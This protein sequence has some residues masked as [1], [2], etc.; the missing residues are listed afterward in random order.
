MHGRENN[1]IRVTLMPEYVAPKKNDS[2]REV[3]KKKKELENAKKP[4]RKGLCRE[5]KKEEKENHVKK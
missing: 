2:L 3:P 1:L 4:K 5:R